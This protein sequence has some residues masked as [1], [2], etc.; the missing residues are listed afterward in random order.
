M[1][2][3]E[4]ISLADIS[5]CGSIPKLKNTQNIKG[6]MLM[7]FKTWLLSGVMALLFAGGFLFAGGDVI[8]PIPW[9]QIIGVTLWG[10]TMVHCPVVAEASSLPIPIM[11]VSF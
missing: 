7:K 5:G 6:E 11:P 8:F 3:T 10:D 1:S 2:I 4:C 9:G